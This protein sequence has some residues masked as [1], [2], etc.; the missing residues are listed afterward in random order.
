MARRINQIVSKAIEEQ[1][2]IWQ[3]EAENRNTTEERRKT[4]ASKRKHLSSS[5]PE[6]DEV[7]TEEKREQKESFN[8]KVPTPVKEYKKSKTGAKN[9]KQ[10]NK[11][12]RTMSPQKGEQTGSS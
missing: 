12:Q 6:D 1:D 10:V 9:T 8:F 11:K 5:D 2:R 7:F 4:L 3:A